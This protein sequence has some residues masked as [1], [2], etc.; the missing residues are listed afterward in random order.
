M[1]SLTCSQFGGPCEEAFTGET[2]DVLVKTATEHVMSSDDDA[3]KATA[4]QMQNMSDEERNAW[5][6]EMQTKVDGAPEVQ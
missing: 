6:E 2:L 3:H 4:D 5:N 1:K